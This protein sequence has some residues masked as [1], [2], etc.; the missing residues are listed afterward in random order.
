MIRLIVADDHPVVREGLKAVISRHRDMSVVGEADDGDS[1]VEIC[2]KGDVD[3]L[4]LDVSMP[5]PGVLEVIRRLKTT[6]P[7]LRIL[8]L[9]MHRESE[10]ARRVLQT[11]ADGYL[12]KSHS[13]T[14]LAT[15]IR[16]AYGGRKYVTPSLAEEMALDLVE[17][18][19]QDAHETLSNREYEVFLQ[20]GSGHRTDEIAR[21][22]TLSPKTVRTYRSRILDKMNLRSTAELIFYAAQRGLVTET[23]TT[24]RVGEDGPVDAQAIPP[25]PPICTTA[26][27]GRMNCFS[28]AK[29]SR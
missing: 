24:D 5:G 25:V 26:S 12:T 11:G 1:A 3:A 21:R 9:S 18:R 20:L 15:A 4:L 27:A 7:K 23:A 2:R 8:V 16:Q 6:V 22:L 13:P 28:S 19:N 10:Y 17:G 14:M 29:P